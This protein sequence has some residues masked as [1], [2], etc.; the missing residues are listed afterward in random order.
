MPWYKDFFDKWYLEIYRDRPLF[1]EK[2]IQKE[3]TFIR[4]VLNL[5][6]GAKVLDLCSGHGRHTIP[7]AKTGY[8][9]TALDLNKKFLSILK[10]EAKEQKLD[11]RIIHSDMRDIPFMNEFDGIINIFTSFGYFTND[12]ENLKV[13]EQVFRALKPAGKFLLDVVNKEWVQRNTHIENKYK[14]KKYSVLEKIKFNQGTNQWKA[15]FAITNGK[16]RNYSA[17]YITKLYSL[18]EIEKMLKQV[19]FDKIIGLFGN[20]VKIEKFTPQSKRLVILA[21]K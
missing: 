6:E 21:Q 14:I 1:K 18:A 3:F 12:K 9:M 5:P 4:R 8:Q 19:G 16:G 17:K 7:L 10:R 15:N 2:N 20:T 11:I 13:L